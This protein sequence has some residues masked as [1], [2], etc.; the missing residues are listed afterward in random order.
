[1]RLRAAWLMFAVVLMPGRPKD[2]TVVPVRTGWLLLAICAFGG[3]DGR[4]DP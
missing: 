4:R 1:M 2:L 3:E